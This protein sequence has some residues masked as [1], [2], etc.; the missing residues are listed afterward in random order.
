VN[1]SAYQ[2][3]VVIVGPEEPAYSVLRKLRAARSTVA[4][5]RGPG[6]RPVGR[7]TWEDLIRKLVSAAGR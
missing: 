7:V 1:V 6:A 3:R 5:V 4:A 2:R